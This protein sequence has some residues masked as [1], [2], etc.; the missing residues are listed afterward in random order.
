MIKKKINQKGA[1]LIEAILALGII[2]VVVMSLVT[3]LV[4][5]L[6]SSNF[7]KNQ[8]LATGYAQEGIEI[9]RDI[10]DQ[11]FSKLSSYS[12]AYCLGVDDSIPQDTASPTGKCI[13]NID[14]FSRSIYVNNSGKDDRPGAS[15]GSKCKNP[16]DDPAGSVT[17]VFVASTVSWNDSKCSGNENCHKVELNSCLTNLNNI[18]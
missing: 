14:T 2:S 12:G 9:M 13:N 5:S 1:V 7:S 4:S 16:P 17:P 6:S 3:A 11:D 10:R 8:T 18:L 15:P